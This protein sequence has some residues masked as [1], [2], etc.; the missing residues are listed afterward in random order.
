MV[1]GRKTD[2]LVVQM[3]L[4]LLTRNGGVRL[5]RAFSQNPSTKRVLAVGGATTSLPSPPSFGGNQ[6]R[7][8][9]ELGASVEEDLDQA[10]SSFLDEPKSSKASGLVDVIPTK[11]QAAHLEPVKLSDI[12]DDTEVCSISKLHEQDTLCHVSSSLFL[13]FQIGP[14]F[15][16][17]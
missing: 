13:Q 4:S 6:Q 7:F 2:I 14:E 3:L 16:F 12:L 9:S 8:K 11:K 10:L 5:A 15:R 17:L 1:F